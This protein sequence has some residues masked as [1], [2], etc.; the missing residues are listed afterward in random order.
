[1]SDYG[2]LLGLTGLAFQFLAGAAW[3]SKRVRMALP[4]PV[5]S[6]EIWLTALGLV[7]EVVGVLMVSL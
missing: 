4:L 2:L 5:E 3:S 7:C 1:M 6:S